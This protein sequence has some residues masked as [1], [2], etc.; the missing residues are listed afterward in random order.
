MTQREA[1]QLITKAVREIEEAIGLK[2]IRATYADGNVD[3]HTDEAGPFCPACQSSLSKGMVKTSSYYYFCTNEQCPRHLLLAHGGVSKPGLGFA[4]D[5][6]P[7][8]KSAKSEEP[9][10]PEEF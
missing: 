8:F 1:T 4:P 9:G 6:K 3:I 2:I 5:R 10:E 7:V